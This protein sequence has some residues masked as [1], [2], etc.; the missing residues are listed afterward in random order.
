MRE[1]LPDDFQPHEVQD[2]DI[3]REQA[4][5]AGQ[6]RRLPQPENRRCRDRLPKAE[7]LSKDERAQLTKIL[8][9][10]PTRLVFFVRNS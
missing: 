2:P 3:A 1:L 9:E 6:D 8:R 10:D 5:Q 7:R 4:I